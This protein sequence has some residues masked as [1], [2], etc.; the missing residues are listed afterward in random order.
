[1]TD[2]GI[3][4]QNLLRTLPDV[5]KNSP[6]FFPLAQITAQA[7]ATRLSEIDRLRLYPAIDEL[8]EPVLDMLAHDFKVDWWDP[9]YSLDEKR[10]TLKSSWQVHRILGTKAAVETALSAV[11]P[12]SKV[13]EWFEYGGEPYHF[14]LLI[15]ST[16]ERADPQKHQ[17]VLERVNYYK[18]LRSHLDRIE[19]S[20]VPKGACAAFAFLSPAGLGGTISVE[21]IPYGLE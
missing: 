1:M 8:D 20:A 16:F 10:R 19:Y 13:L 5:L 4:E 21:V 6:D 9:A 15:D 7:L 17:R 2:Y 18:N 14:K 12:D 3:S 11:Y